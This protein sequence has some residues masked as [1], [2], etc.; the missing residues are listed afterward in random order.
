MATTII[1]NY[2]IKEEDGSQR[3]IAQKNLEKMA[4]ILITSPVRHHKFVLTLI[5]KI[6][7]IL[8]DALNTEIN[9]DADEDENRIQQ[10]QQPQPQERPTP[11]PPQPIQQQPPIQPISLTNQYNRRNPFVNVLDVASAS[12]AFDIIKTNSFSEDMHF[13]DFVYNPTLLGFQDNSMLPTYPPSYMYNN[14]NTAQSPTASRPWVPTT[15]PV[16]LNNPSEER[17]FLVHQQPQF[18]DPRMTASPSSSSQADSTPTMKPN[19][20]YNPPYNNN[21]YY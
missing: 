1:Y 2:V 15:Q 5:S 17:P 11:P 12:S 9:F 20:F 7:A 21:N 16:M 19:H 13:S 4:K 14:D 8:Q 10:Q 3:E 18:Q 6:R